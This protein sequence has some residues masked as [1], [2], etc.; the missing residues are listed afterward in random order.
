MPS[1][2]SV[3]EEYTSQLETVWTG[4]PSAIK[5]LHDNCLVCCVHI[6]LTLS[7]SLRS[8]KKFFQ[9][10]LMTAGVLFVP[11]YTHQSNLP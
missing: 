7:Q 10:H 2:I 6:G 3:E 8:D 11:T 5:N 4:A 1:L 9:V